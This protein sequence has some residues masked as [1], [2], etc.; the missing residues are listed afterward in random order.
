MPMYS[1]PDV[2]AALRFWA[3]GGSWRARGKLPNVMLLNGSWD[4]ILVSAPEHTP[5]GFHEIDFH[6]ETWSEITVPSNWECEGFD[7]PI[8]TN[9]IYPFPINPPYA[10]RRAYGQQNKNLTAARLAAN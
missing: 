1:F 6:D 10:N 4:F 7:R 5:H 9:V 2:Q 3:A 8:Y